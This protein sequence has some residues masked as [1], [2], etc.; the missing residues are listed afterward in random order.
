R[1]GRKHRASGELA[2][3]VLDIMHAFHDASDQG[4]RVD[5]EST[6]ERPAALPVGLKPGT[7][8]E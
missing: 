6:C 2:Y 7:L 3:H 4:K 8:D 1:S 5:L